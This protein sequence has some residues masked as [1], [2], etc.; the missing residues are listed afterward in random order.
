MTINNILE[1]LRD[2]GIFRYF[3]YALA[4]L[5][6]IFFLVRNSIVQIIFQNRCASIKN[7]YG[8]TI[9][10]Q[11]IGFSGLQNIYVENLS[12]KVENRD[13]LFSINRAEAKLNFTDLV[14]LKINPLEIWISNPKI[15][16][17][18]EKNNSNY[19]FLAGNRIDS[20]QIQHSSVDESNSHGNRQY[21]IY[22]LVKAIFGLTTAK[23]HVS[24][25]VLNYSDSTYTTHISVPEFESNANGFNTQIEVY[26]NGDKYFI[27][28]NGLADK[29]KSDITLKAVMVGEKKPLP[30][31]NHKFGLNI[32]FDTLGLRITTKELS[33][34]NIHLEIN[35]SVKS[36][37]LFSQRLSDQNVNVKHGACY[38]D[39]AINSEYYLIDST[40]TIDLNGLKA[41]LYLEYIP[42]DKRS[43]TLKIN[44]G[45]FQSQQLFDA[46]P[47]GL[48]TN[49][50]GIKTNG[51]IDYS[52]DFKVRL[53][54]PDSVYLNPKLITRSFGLVQYGYRNFSALNDT[55]SHD[56]YDEGQYIRTI[57]IDPSNKNFKRLDEISPFIIDAVVTSEDGGFFT[58]QGFDLDAFKY[59]ISENIK[60]KR[61]ARGGSTITMQLVKNL[62]LSKNKNLFRKAEEYLIVWLIEN[63][64]IVSKER[65][66][67]IY[68]NIIE[69]GPNVYGVSEACQYYFNKSPKNVTL[70]EALYLASIVP[71]PKKFKYLFEKDGNLKS[72]MEDDFKFVSNKM[73]SRG[74]ISEDQFNNLTYNIRLNG[75][76]KNILVDTT[77]TISD[78]IS[79]DDVNIA[80]D[81]ALL[82][83]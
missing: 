55:F 58:N 38:I 57:R 70:D 68:L 56:V 60:Q 9:S 79:I 13:T 51:T 32:S 30:L 22:R 17:Q 25:F 8:F 21:A 7:R 49:L 78:S 46:L 34:D 36:L 19:N 77:S 63:Q 24:N 3:L 42:S 44:T 74:M 54:N 61:Y 76:A 72:F 28:L 62:Y 52:L 23:Y 12:A 53:D 11:K 10:T 31:L 20:L 69:W 65:L 15:N 81:T 67:E 35:S 43:F 2:R 27:D 14:F 73:L 33:R 1:R 37:D 39:I 64:A 18:G 50:K 59:A 80:R 4:I 29:D 26:E 83:P 71:R 6:I 75:Q 66:L 47:D 5:I 16:L 45:V 40:S 82:L 48:F 41:K